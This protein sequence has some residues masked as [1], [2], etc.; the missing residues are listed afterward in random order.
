MYRKRQGMI[1]LYIVDG[2]SINQNE[3]GTQVIEIQYH[4]QPFKKLHHLWVCSR[5]FVGKRDAGE[6]GLPG[7]LRFGHWGYCQDIDNCDHGKETTKKI[8]ISQNLH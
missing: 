4:P 5:V 3:N 8:G 2:P 7:R 6:D 1:R